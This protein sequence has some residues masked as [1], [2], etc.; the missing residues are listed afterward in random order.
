MHARASSTVQGD[1]WGKR[2]RDR[3]L[4][5]LFIQ[6]T[7]ANTLWT[8]TH[9]NYHTD[10]SFSKHPPCHQPPLTSRLWAVVSLQS[11]ASTTGHSHFILLVIRPT[12]THTFTRLHCRSTD[13]RPP[14]ALAPTHDSDEPAPMAQTRL[15]CTRVCTTGISGH[16]QPPALSMQ[17][18][19]WSGNGRVRHLGVADSLQLLTL[20]R[21]VTDRPMTH[22]GLWS[23]ATHK[24]A[25][26]PEAEPPSHPVSRR[27]SLP[28]FP[29]LRQVQDP[30]RRLLLQ[31]PLHGERLL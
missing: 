25:C 24:H 18:S 27:S 7:H 30:K 19:Q 10:I 3:V 9:A 22:F 28:V 4:D 17:M 12:G 5:H 15:S 29:A 16:S 2:P 1:Q 20:Q 14:L 8:H 31:P 26:L 23:H 6:H 21:R 11:L 13:S